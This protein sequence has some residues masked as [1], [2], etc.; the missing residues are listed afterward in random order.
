LKTYALQTGKTESFSSPLL[1]VRADNC[2]AT[3]SVTTTQLARDVPKS[4]DRNPVPNEIKKPKIS[5]TPIISKI[6]SSKEF[7][8]FVEGDD[9][10][11]VVKFH[12]TWCQI[13]RAVV[14]KFAKFA[15]NYGDREIIDAGNT[16]SGRAVVPGLVRF[17]DVEW[18]QN[19]ELCKAL[20]VQKF[21][22][23]MIYEKGEKIGAFSTGPAHNFR[24]IVGKTIEEKLALSDDEKEEFR[25]KFVKN[26][27]EGKD[28]LEIIRGFIDDDKSAGA[29][30]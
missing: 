3:S 26:I 20:K 1:S 18:S 24:N 7:L 9:R 12:A 17:A 27:A 16:S 23:I 30:C 25:S 28:D 13:C 15:L 10:L 19:T 22:F 11:C 6:N 14:R 21:P 29:P 5:A 2:V 4:L 8:D